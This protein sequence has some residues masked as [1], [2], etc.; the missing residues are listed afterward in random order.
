M[1]LNTGWR[2]VE[3]N[4]RASKRRYDGNGDTAETY[5]L[6]QYGFC[7]HVHIVPKIHSCPFE[8][9]FVRYGTLMLM[10]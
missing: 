7:E 3:I 6:P 4:Q 2:F 8:G 5:A 1:G 9:I 10:I